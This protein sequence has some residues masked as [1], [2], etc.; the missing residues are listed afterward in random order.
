ML[1]IVSAVV[2]APSVDATAVALSEDAVAVDEDSVEAAADDVVLLSV[3]VE[4]SL[5]TPQAASE[6]IRVR[7][8]AEDANLYQKRW[9]EL[10]CEVVMERANRPT[11][12]QM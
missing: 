3:V 6:L 11:L 5:D 2:D 10:R 1:V 4:A 12:F 8:A 9:G 7:A